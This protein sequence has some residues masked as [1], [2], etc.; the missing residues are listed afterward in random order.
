L[1]YKTTDLCDEHSDILQIADPIFADFGGITTFSG[2]IATVKTFED[3]SL[4]RSTLESAGE[5]RVLVVDGGA[6]MRCALLGDNL[7]QLA[8][9]NDWQGVV[10]NGCIRDS[11]D[12]AD[13]RIGVKA[14]DTH[15]LKSV[16]KDYGQTEVPLT[17]AGITFTPGH[18]LYA[19]QDGL[20]ISPEELPQMSF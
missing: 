4:V 10:V 9:D 20:V 17:F 5:G 15:P 12:I 16:K 7:A 3:N 14:L 19:D 11:E 18:Y 6:S 8:I 13:M 1:N 2:P